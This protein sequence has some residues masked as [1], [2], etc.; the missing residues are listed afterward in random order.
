MERPPR[1]LEKRLGA[2]HVRHEEPARVEHGQAV[3][4]LGG[5]MD[6][7]VDAVS[8][9]G[10]LHVVEVTDVAL[11]ED[12]AVSR[13]D[14]ALPVAG[15]RKRVVDHDR[16]VRVGGGPVP[17]EIRADEARA[18]GHQHVHG[19]QSYGVRAHVAIPRGDPRR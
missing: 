8:V 11:D 17:H 10:P 15:V 6:D 19:E 14:E 3:V 9:E 2:D 5:E 12:D 4:G 7:H 16:V 1:R 18:P 13:S